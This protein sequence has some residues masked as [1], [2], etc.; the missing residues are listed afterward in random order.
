MDKLERGK[1][2]KTIVLGGV[3][4]IHGLLSPE[5]YPVLMVKF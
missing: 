4:Y 5:L 1:I 2:L 3:S